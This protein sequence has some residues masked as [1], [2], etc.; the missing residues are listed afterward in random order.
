MKRRGIPDI[1]PDPDRY[2]QRYGGGDGVEGAKVERGG[3]LDYGCHLVDMQG[4]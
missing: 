4:R 1:L 2:I 3:V